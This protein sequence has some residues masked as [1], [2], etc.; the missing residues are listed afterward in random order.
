MPLE[1]PQI[2]LAE[3][4][5][6]SLAVWQVSEVVIEIVSNRKEMS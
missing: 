4:L 1:H 3:P 6:F 2:V 5:L